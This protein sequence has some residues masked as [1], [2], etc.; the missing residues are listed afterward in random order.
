MMM[1]G[2]SFLSLLMVLLGGQ[3]GVPLSL[4]PLPE[5]PVMARV[6]PADCIW[7][8][9]WSGVAQPNPK[10]TNQTEQLLAE[11]EVR[12]FIHGAGKA[13]AAAIRKGAPPT[14]QGSI[15]GTEGPRL[16]YALLTHPAAA[17]ISK[18]GIG[19]G[20][21]EVEGGIVVGTGAQTEKLQA[22]L[23]K[24]E[25][26]LLHTAPNGPSAGSGQAGAWHKLPSQPG[27]PTIEWGF[28]GNYLILGIGDGSADAISAR[29][30]GQVPDWLT[31]IRKQLPVER[32]STVH[33]LNVK[34]IIEAAGPLLG[35]R[36]PLVLQALGLDKVTEFANVSGLDDHG[37]VSKTW[38]GIDGDPSG[39]LTLFGSEPLAAADLAP[40]PKDA[41]LGIAARMNLGQVWTTITASVSKIDANAGDELAD[42]I[43]Q[44]ESSLGFRL[45]EDLLQ[46]LGD[47][48]CVYNSPGEGG[49]LITGLTV[50]VPLKD[51]DRLVATNVKLASAIQSMN[52]SGTAGSPR[53]RHERNDVSEAENLL[54]AAARRRHA[55]RAVVV[56]HRYA[57]DPLAFAAKHPG[58][59]LAQSGG[60]FAGRSARRGVAD[61]CGQAGIAHVSRHGRDVESDLPHR[62]DR[63]DDWLFRNAARGARS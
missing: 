45:Q 31:A 15:L 63:R 36:G 12:D 10:S 42:G 11:P 37:C 39:L 32:T 3:A 50:V 40:I 27:A 51:H 14:P 47:S 16:I 54:A 41:S 29:T 25:A 48:S 43:K 49:L 30:T 57:I 55:V 53:V 28:R 62:A 18:V 1:A 19:P 17:F 38:I 24:L 46:T 5:D 4:P 22:T 9:S 21:P 34:K 23:E 52:H 44:M 60:R 13:L 8:L 33:Y 20:G 6:A 58:V 2:P 35:L 7:Y 61:Q 56:H 59:S 26:T